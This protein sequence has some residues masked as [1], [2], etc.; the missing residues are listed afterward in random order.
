[1]TGSGSALLVLCDD[2]DEARTVLTQMGEDLR[3]QCLVVQQ[4]PW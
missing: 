4:N 1:M 2:E 3:P